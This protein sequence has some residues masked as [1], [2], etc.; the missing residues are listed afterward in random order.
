ML[1]DDEPPM[2]P[3]FEWLTA[4]NEAFGITDDRGHARRLAGAALD[5]WRDF[6]RKRA[7]QRVIEGRS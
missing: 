2:Q 5:T 7:R 3:A 6:T 1:R 4:L